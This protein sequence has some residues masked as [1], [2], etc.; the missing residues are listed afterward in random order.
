MG[1]LLRPIIKPTKIQKEFISEF[2][3][4]RPPASRKCKLTRLRERRPAPL[5]S[6]LGA[7]T[8]SGLPGLSG[9]DV[10][11]RSDCGPKESQ[12]KALHRQFKAQNL[13]ILGKNS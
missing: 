7:G 13:D 4:S 3:S 10:C 11:H 8:R 12:R 1:A 6:G 5:R 2:T 9:P